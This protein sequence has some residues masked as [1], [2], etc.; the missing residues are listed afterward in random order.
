M[1]GVVKRAGIAYGQLLDLL[2]VYAIEVRSPVTDACLSDPISDEG[3]TSTSQRSEAGSKERACIAWAGLVRATS[4]WTVPLH[5][6]LV[7]IA[8][9][10]HRLPRSARIRPYTLSAACRSFRQVSVVGVLS[11]LS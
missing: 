3:Q 2:S 10:R 11:S 7:Q 6:L 1:P 9:G 8:C 5:C 4:D